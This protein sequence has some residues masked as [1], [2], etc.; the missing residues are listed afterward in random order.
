MD[1]DMGTW[2]L[3]LHD[4]APA[5]PTEETYELMGKV[6][7]LSFMEEQRLKREGHKNG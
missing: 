1:I 3:R 4:D 5:E 6:C 7:Y 2:I